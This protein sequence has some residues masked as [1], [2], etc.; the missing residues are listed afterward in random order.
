MTMQTTSLPIQVSAASPAPNSRADLRAN[1]SLPNDGV[2]FGATLTR[3]I[4]QRQL[5]QRQALAQPQPQPATTAPVAVAAP[6]PQAAPKPDAKAPAREAAKEPA[7]ATAQ[8][9]GTDKADAAKARAEEKT[10]TAESDSAGEPATAPDA[11]VADSVVD[12]LAMVASFNQVQQAV[13]VPA[14]SETVTAQPGALI[15]TLKGK[16]ADGTEPIVKLDGDAQLAAVTEQPQGKAEPGI[17]LRALDLGKAAEALKLPV[18]NGDF[19]AKL[20]DTVAQAAVKEPAPAA[21]AL[22]SLAAQASVL[23]TAQASG[24]A[25]T[26]RLSARVGTPAW[27]NQV[28]QKVIWMVGGED[29]SATLEL[30]PPD[31]GPVQVVLNVSNDLASV[32]FSSQQLEVRQAL[33]NA[34]P[35]LR[36]MM[37]ESGIAL[38]EA[39]VNAGAEGRQG[40]DGQG[41]GRPGRG[42]GGTG[43]GG[44][45]VVAEA[46][47]RQRILG[48]AGAVDTFA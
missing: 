10:A 47:P 27:D 37:S 16:L 15:E 40:Q 25:P 2:N 7:K 20:R 39:L 30:N 12:M 43:T 9:D 29:Q 45:S 26:D 41:S 13:A 44:D 4:E 24:G 38:G 1:A 17:D 36:E 8:A 18:E 32:T 46:A 28:G 35:R 21:E 31:L 42:N 22:T 5:E 33:E 34:L 11:K 3:Q 19:A 6:K 48:G 23:Q 14:A